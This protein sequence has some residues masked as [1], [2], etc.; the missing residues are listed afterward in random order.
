M[1]GESHPKIQRVLVGFVQWIMRM[2][3]DDVV[4]PIT[5]PLLTP[6]LAAL[7]QPETPV[8]LRQVFYISIGLIVN[9][10]PKLIQQRPEI[11][12]FLFE[13]AIREPPTVKVSITE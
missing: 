4:L 1:R 3:S 13:A 9:R 7:E 8:D 11:L 10:K 2:G 12:R 6:L 5:E